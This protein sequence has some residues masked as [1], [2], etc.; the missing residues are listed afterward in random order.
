MKTTGFVL[1]SIFLLT[2]CQSIDEQAIYRPDNEPLGSTVQA[3]FA[4]MVD[5][6]QQSDPVLGRVYFDFDNAVLTEVAKAQ[7]DHVA[8]QVARREGYVMVEGYTDHINTDD[9]NRTLGYKR[10][11][12]VANY[13]RSEG[14]WDERL[15][16][17]SYGEERPSTTNWKDM[18]RALNRCVVVRM[19][20]QGEGANGKEAK[21][22]FEGTLV[23]KADAKGSSTSIPLM[24]P[25][26]TGTT[27][28]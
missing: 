12:V 16:V 28:P 27:T 8:S 6:A 5:N 20:A 9:F 10:A 1:L 14:V 4:M 17:R 7:L 15:V 2:G 3:P 11:L 24:P 26:A 22:A 18:G 19:F 23:K 25:A 13:L 21:K